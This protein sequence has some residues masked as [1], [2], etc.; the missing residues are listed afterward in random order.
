MLQAIQVWI[1]RYLA[2][3]GEAPVEQIG[4]ERRRA[5]VEMSLVAV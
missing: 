1:E 4:R 3:H 2:R 5:S